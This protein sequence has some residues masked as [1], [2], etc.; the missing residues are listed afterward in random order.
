MLCRREFRGVSCVTA[1]RP[2]NT[3]NDALRVVFVSE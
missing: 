2:T 1:A 3:V